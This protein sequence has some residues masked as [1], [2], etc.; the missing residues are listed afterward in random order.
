MPQITP[1][2]AVGRGKFPFVFWHLG[3]TVADDRTALRG[4]VL[5]PV[6]LKEHREAIFVALQVGPALAVELPCAL[7]NAS[8]CIGPSQQEVNAV[9][10]V[11][12]LGRQGELLALE[13]L[14]ALEGNRHLLSL[15]PHG[16]V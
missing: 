4:K 5:D 2:G 11:E 16:V 9:D 10:R 8:G 1:F 6:D 7:V 14:F 13:L 3:V 15:A 12:R